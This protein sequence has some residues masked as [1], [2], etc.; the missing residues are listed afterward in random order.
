MP[1]KNARVVALGGG[2]G[3]AL[4]LQAVR[5]YASTITAV[6]SVADDGGSSG[7]L[8]RDLGVAAPGDLRKCLVAL[9][10]GDGPWPAALE[11]RFASGELS[12]HPLGN[13]MLVGLAE[14]LGDLTAALDEIGH[15][16]G[17]VGRVV[18]ATIDPVSVMADIGGRSVIGQVAV[19]SMARSATVQRVE[20]VPA[21]P[22]ASPAALAA[23]AAADQIVLAPGSL[24]TS[25]LAVLCVPE[26]RDAISAAPGRVVNVCN[27]QTDGETAGLDGTDHLRIILDHGGRV[28]TLLFDP[29][30]GLAVSETAVE[31]FGVSPQSAAIAA[32]NGP[33]SGQGHDPARLAAALAALL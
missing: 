12:G 28:D 23:I 33:S 26:I 27:L 18:P 7:R 16:L 5:R 25:V 14:S 15:L 22:P 24:Y 19:E 13:L 30:A 31:E 21:D 2:H 17:A 6:V 20:L 10:S 9:A 3:L 29:V 1:A 4:T 32:G 11:H 8:R